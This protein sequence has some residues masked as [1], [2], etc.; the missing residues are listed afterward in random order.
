MH[1][2]ILIGEFPAGGQP[3]PYT[4]IN[5][6]FVPVGLDG[7][8][9]GE[10]E[11]LGELAAGGDLLDGVVVADEEGP[12]GGGGEGERRGQLGAVEGA[13]HEHGAVAQ[14]DRRAV[15]AVQHALLVVVPAMV[16]EL[17]V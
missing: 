16:R 14:E 6:L 2:V 4:F 8:E 7:G 10:V 12:V 13:A 11:H 1:R 17:I 5:S 15:A 3:R 9:A